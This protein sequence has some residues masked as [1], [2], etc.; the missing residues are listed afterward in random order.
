MNEVTKKEYCET[1]NRV[2]TECIK[3]IRKLA[4]DAYILLGGYYNNSVEALKDLAKPYDD[5]IVYNFHCY[6]PLLFTHQGAHWIPTMDTA[7]RCN[8]RMTYKEYNEGGVKYL[9]WT[10]DRCM[11]Y[12]DGEVISEKFFEDL[13]KEAVRVAEERNVPLYCGEYGVIELA[14]RN[15]AR[16]WFRDFHHVMDKYSVGRAVWTYKEMDFEIDGSF[17]K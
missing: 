3:R 7:F 8:Y 11:N 10:P 16:E 6:E 4:P 15:D 5:H 13:I 1:W 12:P 14:D 17:G 2:S 9:G